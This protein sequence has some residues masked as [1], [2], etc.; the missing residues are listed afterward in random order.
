MTEKQSYHR[1]GLFVV[2]SLAILAGL[3]FVLGGRS[4]FAPTMVFETYFDK[5]VSGLGIGAQVSFRGV[6]LGQVSEILLS[7]V[8]Y[9]DG[10]PFEQRVAYIVVRAKDAS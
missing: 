9:E 4:L 5:S 8:A 7:S 1:L 2:L 3:L 6:P 10:V